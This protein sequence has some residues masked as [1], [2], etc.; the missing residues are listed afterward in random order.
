[1]VK[2]GAVVKAF[3][4]DLRDWFEVTA[5][6][7]YRVSLEMDA[8][9]AGVSGGGKAAREYRLFDVGINPLDL[10]PAR[11]PGNEPMKEGEEERLRGMILAG[12]AGEKRGDALPK[13]VEL[14]NFW[15]RGYRWMNSAGDE[16]EV[17]LLFLQ[18]WDKAKALDGFEPGSVRAALEKRIAVE[19]RYAL[20]LYLAGVAARKGSQVAG[21]VLLEGMKNTDERVARNVHYAILV[22]LRGNDGQPVD[23]LVEL[24]MA[25]IG[26]TRK[27][28]G[29]R[30]MHYGPG[31]SFTVGYLAEQDACLTGALGDLKCVR[32]IPFLIQQVK[33]RQSERAMSALGQIGAGNDCL[34]EV[35]A[36]AEGEMSLRQGTVPGTF[37]SAVWALGQLK[38]KRAVPILVRRM[39]NSSVIEALEKIGDAAA[40]PALE[41][42]VA[43]GKGMQVKGSDAEA[44]E[45]CVRA[46][47]IAL[48]TLKEGDAFPRYWALMEDQTLGKTGQWEVISRIRVQGDKRSIPR[49]MELIR[50]DPAGPLVIWAIIALGDFKNDK[51]AA[52]GLIA[53]FDLPIEGDKRGK[54]DFSPAFHIGWSL[55]NVTGKSFGDD[56]EA[57]VKWWREEGE[58]VMGK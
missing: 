40:I 29:P 23:W 56:K 32:A 35:L 44:D 54:P 37:S 11:K 19:K 2:S 4:L 36:A 28:T 50:K 45:G 17:E 18:N 43:D 48:A 7:H 14:P 13:L 16:S 52:A 51:T 10:E 22:G 39:C 8:R 58:R 46:A 55:K 41:K 34:L 27:V 12:K 49:L 38:E 31:A 25:A 6:G 47:K 42:V 21:L 20:K 9:T 3:E 24:A 33:E 30:K 1:M 26:D 5:E 57:W 15:P 53:C